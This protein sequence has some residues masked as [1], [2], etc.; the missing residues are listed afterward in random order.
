[1]VKLRDEELNFIRKRSR[2]AKT[3][4]LVGAVLILSTGGL[5]AWLF[6]TKPLLANPWTVWS[7]LEAQ[8]IPDSTLELMAAMLPVV[9]LMCVALFIALILCAFVA[10]SNERKY[11]SILEPIIRPSDESAPN[12][13]SDE[14]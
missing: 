14:P 8:A 9:V 10:F 13:G 1:M 2:L 6:F 7:K 11:L 5:G 12:N 4:P 3:W